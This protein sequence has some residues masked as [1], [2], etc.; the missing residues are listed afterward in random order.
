MSR[1]TPATGILPS[2]QMIGFGDTNAAIGEIGRQKEG[3]LQRQL[4]RD[5]GE[6]NREMERKRMEF[7]LIQSQ[8]AGRMG[9]SRGAMSGMAN[10]KNLY[11]MGQDWN[12]LFQ[13]QRM[14]EQYK[15]QQDEEQRWLTMLQLLRE[16]RK[17][18]LYSGGFGAKVL[19]GMRG[20]AQHDFGMMSNFDSWLEPWMES[21]YGLAGKTP[22]NLP[23]VPQENVPQGP[24]EE[25]GWASRNLDPFQRWLPFGETAI[26]KAVSWATGGP[27]SSKEG[28]YN[29]RSSTRMTP[30]PVQRPGMPP[31]GP[32]PEEEPFSGGRGGRA[33]AP[34]WSTGK[35]ESV[36]GETQPEGPPAPQTPLEAPTGSWDEFG[37]QVARMAGISKEA[38]IKKVQAFFGLLDTAYQHQ[39]LGNNDL[40]TQA[41]GQA[42]DLYKSLKDEGLSTKYIDH[43]L[44]M[45]QQRA[46]GMDNVAEGKVGE[47][48]MSQFAEGSQYAFESAE[49]VNMEERLAKYE[50]ALGLVNQAELLM[51]TDQ[52]GNS[53]VLLANLGPSDWYGMG[54][55]N[56]FGP[57]FEAMTRALFQTKN[58]QETL[59]LL[60]DDNFGNSEYERA[61]GMDKWDPRVRELMVDILTQIPEMIQAEAGLTDSDL[62][63]LFGTENLDPDTGLPIM[64]IEQLKNKRR[65]ERAAY[66]ER[67]AK[68]QREMAE[69]EYRTMMGIEEERDRELQELY[70]RARGVIRGD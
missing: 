62:K 29:P 3:A 22:E 28:P 13:L 38:D 35:P 31:E 68:A 63:D 56:K 14:E 7:E 9:A 10:Q 8:I 21:R 5:E 23:Q 64:T 57:A 51:D 59:D 47:M 43:S 2:V 70:D 58:L 55:Q 66:E 32:F 61:L 33:V 20:I 49:G 30:P 4:M 16:G 42:R 48:A 12:G 54:G 39:K 34:S 17:D 41:R 6:K 19:E 36:P 40:A 46:M 44:W 69:Q 50:W 52:E 67:R 53:R 26:G 37:Y 18:L 15:L 1:I 11:L 45:L 65:D 24:P 27:E 25:Q 60:T